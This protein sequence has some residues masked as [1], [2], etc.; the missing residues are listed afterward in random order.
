MAWDSTGRAFRFRRWS[1]VAAALLI[2]TLMTGVLPSPSETSPAEAAP[3]R[4]WSAGVES[5]VTDLNGDARLSPQPVVPWVK[6]ADDGD[7]TVVVDPTRRYQTMVGFGASMTDSSAYVLSR[8]PA[9]ARRST[10]TDLFAPVDGIGLS[11]LRQ[12][13]GASDFAVGQAYSYDDQPAGGAD[14]DLSDF[15]I[16]HDRAYI[17]PRLREAYRLNPQLTFMASPWSAPG[18]MKD[19]DS[20]ITGSLRPT[21]HRAYAQYFVRFIEAYADAGIPTDYVSMQ[22]E[23]LYEPEDYPGMR[24]MPDQAAVFLG[25]HLGPALDRAG[26]DDTTILGY[27]HNW[28]IPDYP[29][30]LYADRRAAR[31]VPGTAWHCYAGEVVGQ[32]VSHNNYP[33]AQSFLTECSGGQWQGTQD[34]A[35]ELTMGSVIGVPRHWGQSVILWNL[36]LDQRNGP[37]IGGCDVCRGVVTVNDDGTVTKNLEYWALGHS[38]RFVGPG[39]VRIGSSQP[40][41]LPVVNVAYRNRDGSM[42]MVAYN[43]GSQEESFD[44]RVGDRRVTTSLPPGAAATYRWRA[45]ERL[46]PA[47]DLGWVDLDYGRGP[48]GTPTGRLTAS[49]GPEVVDAMNQVRLGDRWLA[50]A[51]PY[52]AELARPDPATILPRDDWTLTADGVT[53][54]EGDVLDN[55]R[56]GDRS[57]QWSSGE[58]QDTDMSLTVDLGGEQTFTEVSL[59][60]G[61]SIADFVRSY[62]L[63][64][65]DDGQSWRSVARGP[66]RSGEMTVA[67]PETTARYL[68]IRSGARSGSWWSIAELNLRRAELGGRSVPIG[69]DLISDRATLGD[70]SRVV[71]FYND[72]RRTQTVPWPVAGFDYDYR[73]PPTA[74]ATFVVLA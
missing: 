73:L 22:N 15:G 36:A 35:F 43:K 9:Q 70:G 68:R 67:L 41:G 62:L 5:W 58:G 20:M 50:Y 72:G 57:T 53:P 64:V 47:G 23:P 27:D 26:L 52:G 2:A 37:F 14:P 11:M 39:A 48:A 25:R 13:M 7:A 21:Y 10:M 69:R 61:A 30:A 56:D 74:A 17:L 71:G 18:W 31:Y 33:H 63:Q 65:S 40:A 16:A 29:E 42:I 6:G 66:G 19:T 45:P 34:E 44:I 24:V 38:S 54:V 12:P 3:A 49:V 28:D 46:A 51:L 32:S 55:L 60:V 8:L 59:D 4:G 1:V